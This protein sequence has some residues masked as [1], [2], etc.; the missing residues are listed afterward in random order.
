M[1]HNFQYIVLLKNAKVTQVNMVHGES[2]IHSGKK[3]TEQIQLGAVKHATE[4]CYVQKK[5]Q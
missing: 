1:H 5:Q 3:H 4:P 2:N